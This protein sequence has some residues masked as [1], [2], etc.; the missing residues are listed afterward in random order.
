VSASDLKRFACFA[1]LSEEEREAFA[2]AVQE[3]DLEAGEEIFRR[4][5]DADGM[6]LVAS[7]RLRVAREQGGLEGTVGPGAVLGAVSLVAP[8]P[9]EADVFADVASRVLW[10]PRSAYRRVAEDAPHAACRF[11]EHV[12]ADF[13]CLVRPGLAQLLRSGVDPAGLEE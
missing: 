10:L 5:E 9:R 11:V 8:G 13:T 2:E 3:V 12:L 4:G 7:G 6:L 1:D